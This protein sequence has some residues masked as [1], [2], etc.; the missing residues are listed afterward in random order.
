[1][2]VMEILSWLI[3]GLEAL[4][5][6]P[7]LYL[8]IVSVAATLNTKRRKRNV[9]AYPAPRARFAILIPAHNEQAVL[10]TL[11]DNLAELNY[12]RDRYAVFVVADNCTDITAD[13]ARARRGVH[14]YE[15]FDQDKRGK[16]YALNWLLRQLKNDHLRFDAYVMLD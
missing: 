1:M 9:D 8:C 15:R 12:P 14:V 7:I 6:L 16:G 10:G 5:A 4:L 13:L 11:L 3:L 2:L